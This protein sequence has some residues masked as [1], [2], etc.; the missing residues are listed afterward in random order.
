MRQLCTSALQY[1]CFH[2][3]KKEKKQT[4]KTN[5]QQVTFPPRIIT[6]WLP[7]WEW[8][9]Y[10][11]HDSVMWWIYFID[12]LLAIVY[13]LFT[14]VYTVSFKEEA[15]F[16]GHFPPKKTCDKNFG[17]QSWSRHK[18]CVTISGSYFWTWLPFRVEN[19]GQAGA[20][21]VLLISRPHLERVSSAPIES[22]GLV[23]GTQPDGLDPILMNVG[24]LGG[25][26]PQVSRC[27]VPTLLTN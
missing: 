19:P 14:R 21:R 3:L 13:T 25:F 18:A 22:M 15:G 23:L 6:I 2:K 16:L 9:I 17:A 27:L 4:N 1:F 24:Y 11:C 7:G 26:P 10:D 20:A 12:K 8:Y 5:I